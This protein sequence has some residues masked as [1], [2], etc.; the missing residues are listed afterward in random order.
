MEVR[1]DCKCMDYEGSGKWEV[2]SGKWEV[3]SGLLWSRVWFA[4]MCF[5]VRKRPNRT[6]QQAAYRESDR[7]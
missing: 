6:N 7:E 4:M 2:E 5:F 3:G 1:L